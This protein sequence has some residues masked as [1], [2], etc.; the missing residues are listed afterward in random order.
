MQYSSPDNT[1]MAVCYAKFLGIMVHT[2]VPTSSNSP[3]R[4][5]MGE[6]TRTESGNEVATQPKGL[7]DMTHCPPDNNMVVEGFS[8]LD[9][10]PD[11]GLT[12][13]LFSWW[14]S[15]YGRDIFPQIP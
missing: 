9:A 13:D 15:M 11:L 14:E 10:V 3:G 6:E 8:D 4:V 7:G 1:H 5:A 2:A 12:S